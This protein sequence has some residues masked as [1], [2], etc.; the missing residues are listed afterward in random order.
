M[1]QIRGQ[2]ASTLHRT[3]SGTLVLALDGGDALASEMNSRS[4]LLLELPSR[5]YMINL[6]IARGPLARFLVK[7]NATPSARL[8]KQAEE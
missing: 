6:L 5:L 1:A 8:L 3:P 4:T 7:H 2:T